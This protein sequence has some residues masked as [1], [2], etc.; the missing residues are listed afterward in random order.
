VPDHPG[1]EDGYPYLAVT[2]FGHRV[3]RIFA[4]PGSVL[5]VHAPGREFI[6]S[7]RQDVRGVR[8]AK[9]WVDDAQVGL[10]REV[11]V[12]EGRITRRV[13]LTL[14]PGRIR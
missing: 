3:D 5:T 12:A 11:T 14:G 6:H 7:Y 13:D 8:V 9:D 2:R 4:K 10:D 1:A